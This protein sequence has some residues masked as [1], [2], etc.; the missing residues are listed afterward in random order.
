MA[1]Y[2]VR[3][4]SV[5][6]SAVV[7]VIFIW[8]FLHLNINVRSVHCPSSRY[9]TNHTQ[10]PSTQ[11]QNPPLEEGE[12]SRK[13]PSALEKEPLRIYVPPDELPKD[14]PLVDILGLHHEASSPPATY[15]D[16]PPQEAPPPIDSSPNTQ[17]CPI[18]PFDISKCL[19]V[20]ALSDSPLLIP[21][22]P[23]SDNPASD[24]PHDRPLIL[25]A[26][27]ESDF[28]R[29]NLAFF[30]N[31]GLHDAADFIFILNG[32][33][34][35]EKT[36]L[37]IGR[38]NIRIIKRENTCF[39]LGAHAEVLSKEEEGGTG[40]ALK[41]RYKRFILMNAS[42]RGPFVPHWSKECWSDAYLGRLTDRVKVCLLSFGLVWF[43]LV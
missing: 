7:V 23:P 9:A 2:S 42:I 6:F 18:Q 34:D 10:T 4:V 19:S 1:V 38:Q 26:Y 35:V 41:D 5:W 17:D 30:V 20:Q 29:I 14:N 8:S 32:E 25:Y 16:E 33:T 36:V 40:K 27:S 24:K 13:K 21:S 12:V 22:N 15:P 43:G 3:S 39:D 31:H 11:P 28:G 37:P